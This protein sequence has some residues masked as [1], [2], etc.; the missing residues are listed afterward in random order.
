VGHRVLA[1]AKLRT[2]CR[3]DDLGTDERA[4]APKIT[5]TKQALRQQLER[6]V[7]VADAEPEGAVDQRGPSP[8]PKPAPPSVATSNPVPRN[9]VVVAKQ[10]RGRR[11][12]TE[13]ELTIPVG[14]KDQI[15]RGPIQARA[16]RRAIS[17][18]A[19]MRD[20][21]QLGNFGS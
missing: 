7:G 15:H 6:T 5:R 21:R 2:S 13:V 14:Q 18:I 4:V 8:A 1:N 16:Y 17:S 11:K 3:E 10:A 20:D 19:E 9:H 12:L